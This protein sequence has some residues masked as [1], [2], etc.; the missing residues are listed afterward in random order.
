MVSLQDQAEAA[1]ILSWRVGL[2]EFSAWVLA[3]VGSA[4][5]MTLVNQVQYTSVFRPMLTR[6]QRVI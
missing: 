3:F 2:T 6:L 1:K 5:G 4:R